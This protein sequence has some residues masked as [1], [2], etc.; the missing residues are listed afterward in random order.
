MLEYIQ[1]YNYDYTSAI[2]NFFAWYNLIGRK[3]LDFLH[4]IFDNLFNA[5]L[6]VAVFVSIIYLGMSL[7]ALFKKRKNSRR[8]MTGIA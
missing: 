4:N 5:L 2:N 8:A 3:I 6:I 7:Y 1:M